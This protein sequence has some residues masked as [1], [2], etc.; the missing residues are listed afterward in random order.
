MMNPLQYGTVGAV[1]G[2]KDPIP[3]ADSLL[4]MQ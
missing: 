4:Q 3:V 1:Q 2:V